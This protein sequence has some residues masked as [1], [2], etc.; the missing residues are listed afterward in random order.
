MTAP[1][2][3]YSQQNYADWKARFERDSQ[4]G[5]LLRYA[6]LSAG[7]TDQPEQAPQG[8]ALLQAPPQEPPPMPPAMQAPE[9]TPEELHEHRKGL[10]G[11]LLHLLGADRQAPEVAALLSPEERDRIRPGVASTLWNAVVE[12]K[13]PQAVQ[14]ERALNI[15]GLR[16]V[17]TARDRTARQ[18]ALTRQIEEIAATMP[19]K[20]GVEYAARMKAIYG[21]PT[22]TAATQ[23]AVGLKDPVPQRVTWREA[24]MMVNGRPAKVLIS[25]TGEVRDAATDA[26]L[27]QPDVR[28]EPMPQQAPPNQFLQ[29]LDAEGQPNYTVVQGRGDVVPRPLPIRRPTSG[30]GTTSLRLQARMDS[31]LEGLQLAQW[32]EDELKANPAAIGLK[33][34]LWTPALD[35]L[36]RAGVSARSAIE[37]L[38]GELRHGRFGGAL[39]ATEAAKAVRWLPT[40]RDTYEGALAKLQ[41]LRVFL[42]ARIE[43]MD[44]GV[45]E[46]SVDVPAPRP[47]TTPIPA[48]GRTYTDPQTGR[49]Y[50]IP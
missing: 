32:V 26:D 8:P 17:R 16:D 13:G 15:V 48:G 35:R 45:G 3:P 20:E 46:E 4:V 10:R 11:G 40:D 27:R 29:S 18:E 44:R 1:Y 33:G 30:S 7:L 28:L 34:M 14:Q 5:G 21:L 2:I 42:N 6:K 41:N 49:T 23:A 37:T 36:D 24:S 47:G 22:S 31:A 12:G 9:P 50:R 19:P 39:T 25:N 38:T 43:A